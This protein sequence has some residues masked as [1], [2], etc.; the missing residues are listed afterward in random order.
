MMPITR[1]AFRLADKN[2]QLRAD[3]KERTS[4]RDALRAR[5]R[6]MTEDINLVTAALPVEKRRDVLSMIRDRHALDLIDDY[7]EDAWR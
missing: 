7:E 6:R 5:V 3:L 4:E 1:L 2:R